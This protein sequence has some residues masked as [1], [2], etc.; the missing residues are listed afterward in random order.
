MNK[1]S[2]YRCTIGNRGPENAAEYTSLQATFPSETCPLID[3]PVPPLLEP[4]LPQPSSHAPGPH[5]PFCEPLHG[6]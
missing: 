5:V 6:L 1:R 3:P 4:R 2:R